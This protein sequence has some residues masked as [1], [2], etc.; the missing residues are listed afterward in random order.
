MDVDDTPPAAS[1]SAQ[2]ARIYLVDPSASSSAQEARSYPVNPPSADKTTDFNPKLDDLSA[3]VDAPPSSQKGLDSLSHMTCT[4]PFPSK[5]ASTIPTR[6]FTPQTL[7][8][9]TLPRSPPTPTKLT[10]SSWSAYCTSFSIYLDKFDKFNSTL[11]DHF[12]TRRLA[13]AKLV[14]SGV[15][16]LEAVGEAS[17]AQGFMSYARGVKEDERVR[18]HWNLGCERHAEAVGTFESV[19]ERVRVLSEGGGM[20]E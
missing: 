16:A 14:K 12:G 17:T 5:A 20:V 10:R 8:L 1:S 6:T 15:R 9:P 19:R 18:E 2:E 13:A 11:L 7:Q 3:A 4:L